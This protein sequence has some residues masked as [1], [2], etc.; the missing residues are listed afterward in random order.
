MITQEFSHENT[1][2]MQISYI[3]EKLNVIADPVLIIILW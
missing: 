1:A 2:Y 3:W